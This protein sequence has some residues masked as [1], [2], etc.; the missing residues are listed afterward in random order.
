MKDDETL[1]DF[2]SSLCDIANESFALDERIPRS[3]LV[4]KIIRFLLDRFQ[5]NVIAIEESKN[6]DI[7]KIDELIGSLQN[8]E[9]NFRQK[10]KDKSIALK[11]T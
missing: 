6:L 9:L 10:R 1:A 11:S 4:W 7:M 2:Y 5:S 8:F 3:K